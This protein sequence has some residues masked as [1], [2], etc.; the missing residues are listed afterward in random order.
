[1]RSSTFLNE[2]QPWAQTATTEALCSFTL[3]SDWRLKERWRVVVMNLFQQNGGMLFPCFFIMLHYEHSV[4][5]KTGILGER[6]RQVKK[7]KQKNTTVPSTLSKKQLVIFSAALITLNPSVR[8]GLCSSAAFGVKTPVAS[9]SKTVQISDRICIITFP[10][11]TKIPS[12]Y[13]QRLKNEWNQNTWSTT[14]VIYPLQRWQPPRSQDETWVSWS[15]FCF[16]GG[17]K[18]SVNRLN[19]LIIIFR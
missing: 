2:I 10:A 1:M 7:T 17:E 18:L 15:H 14:Y 8:A 3:S 6:K 13:W 11:C 16:D 19:E 5:H 9:L 4:C 12:R